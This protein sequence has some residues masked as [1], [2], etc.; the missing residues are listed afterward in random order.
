MSGL[1]RLSRGRRPLW[2]RV[3][4]KMAAAPVPPRMPA[5]RRPHAEAAMGLSIH[6]ADPHTLLLSL[7]A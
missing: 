4:A 5:P 2:S 6:W 7:S 3:V 1:S